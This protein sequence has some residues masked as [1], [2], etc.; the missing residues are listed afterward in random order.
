L[1]HPNSIRLRIESSKQPTDGD[2]YDFELPPEVLRETKEASESEEMLPRADAFSEELPPT[3]TDGDECDFELPGK[4]PG[5]EVSEAIPGTNEVCAEK[6]PGIVVGSSGH[7]F[8]KI[9][10]ARWG[11][12]RPSTSVE[13]PRHTS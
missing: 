1:S 7:V 2:A 8:Y 10:R 11:A 3:L 12:P 13:I 5:E 4:K 6:K 9:T